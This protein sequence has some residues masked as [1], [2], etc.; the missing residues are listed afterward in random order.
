MQHREPPEGWQE[1]RVP[2]PLQM[3]MLVLHQ[4]LRP[5]QK[6]HGFPVCL[7]VFLGT[8][9]PSLYHWISLENL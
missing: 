9:R 4:V 3:R 1:E 6:P 8:A 7:P 2:Q 5:Y